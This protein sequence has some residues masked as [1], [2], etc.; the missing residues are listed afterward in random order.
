MKGKIVTI[1]GPMVAAK[2]EGVK[3]HEQ[4]YVGKSMLVGEVIRLDKDIA[5]MQVYEDTKGLGVGDGIIATGMPLTVSLAPGLLSGIY[6]GL[7]RPLKVLRDV[8]GAFLCSASQISPIDVD[9]TWYFQPVKSAGNEV[10]PG[11]AIGYFEE[12]NFK[13]FVC[14]SRGGKIEV[15]KKEEVK[16]SDIIC[17]F[18][19]GECLN[20]ISKWPVRKPR[21]Y[22][23]KLH[24]SEPL[25]TGQRCIDFLFPIA[26]G[27]TVIFPGGFGTGKTILE[28]SIAKFADVDIVIYVG[29]G[30]R[31][32]EMSELISDFEE[33]NDPWTGNRIME[34]TI[35]VVN[36]SNMPVAAREASI[37]TAVAM[38]EYYRDMGYDVLFLADSLSRW[39]EALRE[40]SSSLEEM[41][42][43]EG[44]PT[45]LASKLAAFFERAGV[46]ETANGTIGSLTMVLSVSPPGGDFTEPVT[47]AALRIAGGFIMLDTAYA[48]RR[49]FPAINYFKSYSLYELDLMDYFIE[50]YSPSWKEKIQRVKE[51]LQKEEKLREITEIIGIEGLSDKD[52]LLMQTADKIKSEF[53]CQ[54]A[55]TKDAFSSPDMTLSKISDILSFYD[56]VLKKLESGLSLNEAV[57]NEV[58]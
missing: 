34:R 14:P 57:K 8:S 20:V 48:H 12:G 28:Q 33:L 49:H 29:C 53:L 15:I 55:F 27:G 3:L 25:I 31:G 22:K 39:A 36:T 21:P 52:R 5:I 37:Y 47:Q 13:H 43:E 56:T 42:G 17:K 50:R 30:E 38:A 35:L 44:Y 11:E 46:V 7:Q 41:P 2:I 54:N 23:R 45:Y 32:N 4:V 58:S 18:E 19:N 16:V 24:T 51:F 9:K 6:D 10:Y 1:S 26:K 40:I